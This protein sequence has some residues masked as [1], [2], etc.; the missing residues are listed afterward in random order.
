[1]YLK[2]TVVGPDINSLLIARGTPGFTGADI[3]NLINIAAIKATIQDK[4]HVTMKDLEEAK[5]DVIMGIKRRGS[6][7][8]KLSRKITAYHEG[9]HALVALY[10]EGSVPLH[11]A[12][13]IQRG[14]ALG[15]VS[16]ISQKN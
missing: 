8:N 14:S 3:A 13:I 1:M 16:E 7:E 12:T 15:M 6:G 4:P 9:G 5:D 11:K 10:T 2:K